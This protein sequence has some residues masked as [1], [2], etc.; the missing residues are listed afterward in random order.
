MMSKCSSLYSYSHSPQNL[1]R[2]ANLLKILVI[3]QCDG[4]GIVALRLS[5]WLWFWFW[6]WC[7]FRLR[8]RFWPNHLAGATNKSGHVWIYLIASTFSIVVAD[9]LFNALPTAAVTSTTRTTAC[10]PTTV[11]CPHTQHSCQFPVDSST[12]RQSDSPTVRQLPVV[13][14]G[15]CSGNVQFISVH[16]FLPPFWRRAVV[17]RATPTIDVDVAYFRFW[18][19]APLTFRNCP[20]PCSC[21][22]PCSSPS[23]SLLLYLPLYLP[24]PLPV[25]VFYLP[26]LPFGGRRTRHNLNSTKNSRRQKN[27]KAKQKNWMEPADKHKLPSYQPDSGDSSDPP[28]IMES[29]LR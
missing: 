15:N 28:G 27:T 21:P 24:H 29:W 4:F 18:H 11:S 1:W 7:W 9:V 2:V 20:C 14:H 26:C 3:A 22:S 17:Q 8:F 23:H 13:G 5:L 6:F 16:F 10:R 12:D 19:V 25:D